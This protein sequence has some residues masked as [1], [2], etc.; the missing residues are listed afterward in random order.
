MITPDDYQMLKDNYEAERKQYCEHF[1]ALWNLLFPD[2][3]DDWD[4]PVQMY[5]LV[6]DKV[7]Y[8]KSVL[9]YYTTGVAGGKAEQALELKAGFSPFVDSEPYEWK[10]E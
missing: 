2:E 7:Y 10:P 1:G 9:E 8:M 6:F 3:K 4:Y 5:R